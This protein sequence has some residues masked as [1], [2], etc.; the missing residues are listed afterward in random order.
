MIY[1]RIDSFTHLVQ[2]PWG[3][4]LDLPWTTALQLKHPFSGVALQLPRT[5]AVQL[6]LPFSGVAAELPRTCFLLC[7][8]FGMLRVAPWLPRRRAVQAERPLSGVAAQLPRTR[9][10]QAEPPTGAA[11]AGQCLSGVQNRPGGGSMGPLSV[12]LM[13]PECHSQDQGEAKIK[14]KPAKGPL[15]SL[16]VIW[17][18]T[19]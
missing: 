17:R 18:Y 11:Q 10:V 7:Q 16:Q 9:A 14:E 2:P 8:R 12:D 19:G 4:G 1:L 13:K 5:S 3:T 6:E 15:L